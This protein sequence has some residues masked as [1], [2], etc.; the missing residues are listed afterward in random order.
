MVKGMDKISKLYFK[1]LA[2]III[3]FIWNHLRRV[4]GFQKSVKLYSTSVLEGIVD[5]I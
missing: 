1:V 4:L 3:G 5:T 2:L